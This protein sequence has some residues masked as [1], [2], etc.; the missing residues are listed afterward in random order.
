LSQKQLSVLN[1]LEKTNTRYEEEN[2]NLVEE[3][4]DLQGKIRQSKKENQDKKTK[5]RKLEAEI[6]QQNLKMQVMEDNIEKIIQDNGAQ[7]V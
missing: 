1:E 6:K 2:K 4:D 3:K 7:F 5:N